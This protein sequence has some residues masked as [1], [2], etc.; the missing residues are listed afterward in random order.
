LEE[1]PVVRVG[2][3][4]DFK[5]VMDLALMGSAENG[6]VR[7]DARK[8]ANEVWPAL[9]QHFG[10]MGVIG[11]PDK[12]EGAVLLRIQQLWYSA[13]WIVEER[14][15]FVHPDF[16]AAKGKRAR[17][18]IQFS[19]EFSEKMNLPLL[20]GVL[21]NQ[22][23]QGK[24]RLYT[25]MFGEPSGAYWLSGGETRGQEKGAALLQEIAA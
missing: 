6:F 20:I 15:I 5:D 12:P 7:P 21:S 24:I 17:K 18:L 25:R 4:N 3:P 8:L 2:T 13:D 14:A 22:R 1:D 11:A 9:N 16:R 10:I 23:T 19:K